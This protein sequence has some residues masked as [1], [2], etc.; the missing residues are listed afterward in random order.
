MGAAADDPTAA[1]ERVSVV[2]SI[3]YCASSAVPR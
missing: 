3:V 1:A 2:A